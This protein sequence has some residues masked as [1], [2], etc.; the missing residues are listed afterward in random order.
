MTLKGLLTNLCIILAANCLTNCSTE[1][2]TADYLDQSKPV[3]LVINDKVDTIGLLDRSKILLQSDSEKIKTFFDWASNNT[4]GWEPDFN[5]YVMADAYLIQ[6]D[7]HLTYYK[8]GFII[9]NIKDKEG[10]PRQIK[11]KVNQGDL[12]F[13]LN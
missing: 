2:N 6:D 1:I 9:L 5:S 8:S 7:F 12:D 13:L 3:E 10:K 11:K 4:E